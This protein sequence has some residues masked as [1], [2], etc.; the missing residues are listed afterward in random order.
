MEDN[1]QHAYKRL[2]DKSQ[3]VFLTGSAGTG[4]STLIRKFVAEH[5]GRVIVLAPTG[6]AAI[7]IG[8][9]TIHSFCHLPAR[10]VSY[11]SIKT[12]NPNEPRDANKIAVI[13]AAEYIIIDEVSMVRAD[14]MDSIGWFF[15]KNFP[16]SPF[17]GKKI[18][19]V[20]DMD[21][22]PPVV[23]TSEER[24]ML[25]TRYNSE[26]F[27]DAKMWQQYAKFEVV[28]LTK[29]WRQ[30]DPYFIGLLNKIKTNTI[31]Y[32]D[33][34]DINIKCVSSDQAASSDS[35]LLASTNKIADVINQTM[36][37]NL[38]GDPIILKGHIK[39][40]FNEKN[41]TVDPQIKVKIGAKVMIV[42][43][44]DGYVNGTIGILK[45]VN[46]NSLI[47]ESAD[48]TIR[49]EKYVFES[50]EYEYDKKED[51][52]SCSPVGS[53]IQF[54]LKIAY[55]ISIHKSQGQTFDKIIIDLGER[56]AFAHGQTY[57]AL[58]R[59]RTLEG[60][61][62]RRPINLKDLIYHKSVL[63]FNEKIAG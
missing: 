37:D 7:N 17:A 14:L 28:K 63:K 6:I 54:P 48:K 30:N 4:K 47:I 16:G 51:K 44:G 45:E 13:K 20:G 18:I 49:L 40:T 42:R 38:P 60:I 31:S 59:C 57:V 19:M 29:I 50:I 39:G 41:C 23:A 27:F 53:F 9:Q 25:T 2:T 8:G 11:N 56:G 34:S 62:L 12:L 43:N 22:L 21:Q 5:E 36:I 55:A 26:F 35:I 24:Q 1:L 58:S 32:Q 15:H 3:H 46:E 33:I 10:V 52:I 61:T